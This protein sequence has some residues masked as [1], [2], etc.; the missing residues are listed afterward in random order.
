MLSAVKE[1]FHTQLKIVFDKLTGAQNEFVRSPQE[2]NQSKS[3]IRS[4]ASPDN[5]SSH[6][7]TTKESISCEV[8]RHIQM[9]GVLKKSN[10]LL[11]EYVL[12]KIE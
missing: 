9:A 10:Y 7:M 5:L 2:T 3:L 1:S 11:S 12:E 6:R 4:Q 8:R